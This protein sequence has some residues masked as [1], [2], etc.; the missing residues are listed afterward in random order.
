MMLVHTAPAVRA[1]PPAAGHPLP[2]VHVAPP[3]PHPVAA[4][5]IVVQ[6]AVRVMTVNPAMLHFVNPVFM[7]PIAP[8][9]PR[10]AFALPS[11]ISPTPAPNDQTL[12]QEPQDAGKTHYLPG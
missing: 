10:S 9:R 11:L 3:A 12:F 2:V 6:P 8:P 1:A 5:P 4:H 7:V